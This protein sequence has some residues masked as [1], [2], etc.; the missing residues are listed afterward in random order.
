MGSCVNITVSGSGSGIMVIG[1]E[2]VDYLSAY[3]GLGCTGE[4]IFVENIPNEC[5]DLG[6]VGAQSFSNDQSVFGKK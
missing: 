4:V 5:I 2:T 3:T 6:G 1:T